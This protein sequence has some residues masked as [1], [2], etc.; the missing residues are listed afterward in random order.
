MLHSTSS[1]FSARAIPILLLAMCM[2]SIAV[3]ARPVPPGQVR[4]SSTTGLPIDAENSQP[5]N[6]TRV[7]PENPGKFQLEVALETY[8]LNGE[9]KESL[10]LRVG[11]ASQYIYRKP[12]HFHF[13][14]KK[15]D[16]RLGYFYF[17]NEEQAAEALVR[18][19]RNATEMQAFP[20]PGDDGNWKFLEDVIVYLIDNYNAVATYTVNNWVAIRPASKITPIPSNG[21]A[22][23]L[24]RTDAQTPRLNGKV[25]MRLG[26]E[27]FISPKRTA[28]ETI[29]FKNATFVPIGY[30]KE[31][32]KVDFDALS[33]HA[34]KHTEFLG[35]EP[36]MK[37]KWLS[38]EFKKKKKELEGFKGMYGKARADY[39][40]EWLFEDGIVDGL[41][42]QNA[43]DMSLVW[44]WIKERDHDM[45]QYLKIVY[46]SHCLGTGIS[47]KRKQDLVDTPP[48]KQRDSKLRGRAIE[49]QPIPPTTIE[50]SSIC[51][52]DHEL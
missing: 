34:A 39:F 6:G 22:I 7:L 31:G 32:V 43:I 35:D 3:I 25:S 38:A 29:A 24:Y 49:P 9:S 26:R 18:A 52:E 4:P 46:A 1:L 27:W 47:G 19:Q 37:S 11:T 17:E 40:G 50:T 42:K 16:T 41:L 2:L 28:K 8:S 10:S 13:K 36:E 20:V 23:I 45:D 48:K 33:E 12:M 15:K 44:E 14:W 21:L 51:R 30:I 5:G